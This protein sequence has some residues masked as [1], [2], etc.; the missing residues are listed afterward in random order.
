ME[1][2]ESD[3]TAISRELAEELDLEVL[4]VGRELAEFRDPGSHFRIV[5]LEVEAKGEPA[6]LE[7]SEIAWVSREG[8]LAYPLAPTDRQFAEEELL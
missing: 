6:A 1:D 7:H 2:G 3:D 8:L 5:F 4:S